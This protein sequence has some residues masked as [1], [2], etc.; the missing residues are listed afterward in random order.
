MSAEK[1]GNLRCEAAS[2]EIPHRTHLH[3]GKPTH[4]TYQDVVPTP[5]VAVQWL[6]EEGV[7]GG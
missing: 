3:Q 7:K 5:R 4:Q 6:T 1:P 2:D